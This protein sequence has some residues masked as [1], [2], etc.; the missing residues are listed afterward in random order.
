M[1]YTFEKTEKS[2]VTVTIKLTEKEWNEAINLAYEKSKGKFSLPGFR[3]GKVPKHLIESTYGK[4]VF[5]EDAINQAFPK[6]YGEFLD[7]ET[8]VEP[9]GSPELDIKDISD[10]GITMVAVIPV[11][12]E[13]ALGEYKGINTPKMNIK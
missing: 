10:K 2:T 5:Y 9:V 11:K 1:K 13:V 7:K 12:P 8:T 3:K 4:G 6:Y